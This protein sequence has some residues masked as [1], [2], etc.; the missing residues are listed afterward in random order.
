MKLTAALIEEG[1]RQHREK[2]D[3]AAERLA[4]KLWA[5]MFGTGLGDAPR[6]RCYSRA[7]FS[8]PVTVGPFDDEGDDE[9]DEN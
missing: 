5:E 9:D 8:A 2:M 3:R 4:D 7:R 1:L 6:K